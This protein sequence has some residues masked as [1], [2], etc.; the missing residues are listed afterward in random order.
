[1]PAAGVTIFYGEDG[2]A[3]LLI[4]SQV[5]LSLQ[6]SFAVVPLVMFT[7]DRRK[8]GA[9]VAPRW[10]TIVAVLIAAVIVALNLKL[11]ADFAIGC[12]WRLGADDH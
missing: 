9:F 8:L 10:L 3:K 2:A 12:T 6:L 7:A 4:F 1:M 5:V 11:L